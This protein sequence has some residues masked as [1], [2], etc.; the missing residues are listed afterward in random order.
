MLAS[1]VTKYPEHAALI[2]Q[3]RSEELQRDLAEEAAAKNSDR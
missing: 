2:A 1:Y 3:A